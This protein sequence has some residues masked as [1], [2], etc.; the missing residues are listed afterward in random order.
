MIAARQST[1][2]AGRIPKLVYELLP[3]FCTPVGLAAVATLDTQLGR[4][5]GALLLACAV[6][7]FTMRRLYRSN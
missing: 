3:F 1:A 2:P 5:S 7:I 4:L 6:A